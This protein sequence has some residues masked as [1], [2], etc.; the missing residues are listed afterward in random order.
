MIR[1]VFVILSSFLM[2]MM[3]GCAKTPK[4]T[5]TYPT[6][7]GPLQQAIDASDNIWIASLTD[8][9]VIEM[10]PAGS[11]VKTFNMTLAPDCAVIDSAGYIWVCNQN[12]DSVT[13]ITPAG[14]V[15]GTYSTGCGPDSIAVDQ[16][17]RIWITNSCDTT[18]TV[19]NAT[20]SLIGTYSTGSGGPWNVV[21][22]SMGNA[23]TDNFYSG[24]VSKISPTGVVLGVFTVGTQPQVPAFDQEGNLWVPNKG[25]NTMTVLNPRGTVI[26]TI[27]LTTITGPEG[28]A[29]DGGDNVWVYGVNSVAEYNHTGQL[30]G[31]YTSGAWT[32][33]AAVDRAGN[34]WVSNNH[35]NTITKIATRSPG[36]FTPTV[37]TLKPIVVRTRFLPNDYKKLDFLSD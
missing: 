35:D 1:R 16:S 12:N 3:T 26:L 27:S 4:V 28:L 19:L 36:V 7:R 11:I 10:N 8:K 17:S 23:W 30:L 24:T 22:D 25:S 33:Y 5:G 21:I 18:V 15:I 29:I 31:T 20:G 34:L 14:S 37:A 9:T 32:A 6:N 2:L 13:R